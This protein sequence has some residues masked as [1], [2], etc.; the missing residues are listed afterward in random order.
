MTDTLLCP[1]CGAPPM[2]GQSHYAYRVACADCYC[3]RG[4]L[5][6]FSQR[7]LDYARRD[8]NDSVDAYTDT[9]WADNWV[10]NRERM[11]D[12]MDAHRDSCKDDDLPHNRAV[13]EAADREYDHDQD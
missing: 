8:W 1:L 11:Y 4:S 5:Q 7:S 6:G 2:E 12:A 13:R 10:T 9:A 3:G